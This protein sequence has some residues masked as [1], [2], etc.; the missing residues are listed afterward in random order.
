MA[1][2]AGRASIPS[3]A[4]RTIRHAPK[5]PL[6]AGVPNWTIRPR[7]TQIWRRG[8][9]ALSTGNVR[10][11]SVPTAPAPREIPYGEEE[12]RPDQAGKL[13]SPSAQAS[14]ASSFQ[15]LAATTSHETIDSTVREMLRPMLTQWLDDNLPSLVE[16][17]VRA[18]IERVARGGR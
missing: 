18:E 8:C 12:P 4:G 1:R 16:R 2:R 6:G 17:L 10:A 5:K 7:S 14:V 3:R 9:A 13:L 11:T 15:A